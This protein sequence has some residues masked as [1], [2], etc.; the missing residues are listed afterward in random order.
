M[1]LGPRPTGRPWT[2]AEDEQLLALLARAGSLVANAA[3]FEKPRPNR[4]RGTAAGEA[5]RI[6]PTLRRKSY[7]TREMAAVEKEPLAPIVIRTT[8]AT[9]QRSPLVRLCSEA[10]RM[11][12]SAENES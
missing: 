10:S 4:G 12:A 9:T 11:A 5:A 7:P 6:E 2:P 1:K 8:P 3:H